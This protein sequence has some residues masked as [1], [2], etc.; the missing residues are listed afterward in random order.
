M[1]RESEKEGEKNDESSSARIVSGRTDYI[2]VVWFSLSESKYKSILQ[3]GKWTF[4][5]QNKLIKSFLF[6]SINFKFQVFLNEY[7]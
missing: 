1:I 7:F 3:N 4:E 6:N 5:L 2:K